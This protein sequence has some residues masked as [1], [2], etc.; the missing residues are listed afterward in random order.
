MFQDMS[1]ALAALDVFPVR[2]RHAV[3]STFIASVLTAFYLEGL[4]HLGYL[5]FFMPLAAPAAKSQ[6]GY[7]RRIIVGYLMLLSIWMLV[8]VLA[9]GLRAGGLAPSLC[10]AG[11][12]FVFLAAWRSGP[13][14]LLYATLGA[15]LATLLSVWASGGQQWTEMALGLIVGGIVYRLAFSAPLEFIDHPRPWSHGFDQFRVLFVGNRKTYWEDSYA[16]GEWQYLRSDR[17]KPRHYAIAGIIRDR[18][19]GG[20]DI[21]DLGCGYGT[22]YPLIKPEAATYVGVDL[23][24]SVI[25]ECRT[26]F[27][28]ESRCRFEACDFET[29][30]PDRKFD[31][32]L[33]NEV[34]YF[35]PLKAVPGA[36]SR[37]QRFLK[38]DKSILVISM[39]NNPKTTWTR[40]RLA[41]CAAPIQSHCVSNERTAGCWTIDT[42]LKTGQCA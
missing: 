28:N 10:A 9:P 18:F 36:F 35:L 14:T 11:V 26:I 5:A 13:G 3:W 15:L 32:V 19:P 39:A 37:V 1:A 33:L 17:E 7:L 25:E 8:A 41:R 31:V 42:Y 4:A 6:D 34:F 16:A 20:A 38:D 21:L 24:E 40:R 12:F 29:Y 22:I 2:Y 23:A 27:K 30:N